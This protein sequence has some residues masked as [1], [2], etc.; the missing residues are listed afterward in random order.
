MSLVRR[1]QCIERC[2]LLFDG[3]GSNSA[4]KCLFKHDLQA[5]ADQMN[6]TIRVAHYPSYCSKYNLIERRFFP[7]LSRVGTGML[8]DTL[9]HVV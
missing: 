7:H 5:V 8:F 9:E 2:L 3:G 6:M 1:A 4:S